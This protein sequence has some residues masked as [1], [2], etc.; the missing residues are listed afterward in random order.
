MAGGLIGG[1]LPGQLWLT[2][3]IPAIAVTLCFFVILPGV[4]ESEGRTGG[5][6]DLLGLTLLS[7]GLLLITAGLTFMRINGPGTW[8]AWVA[9]VLGIA[10]LIPFTATNWVIRIR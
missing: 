2:L 1:A 3:T 7:T 4:P 10:A 6:L 9:V 8:W 5:R